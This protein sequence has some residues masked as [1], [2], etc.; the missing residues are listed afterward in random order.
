MGCGVDPE[1]SL[2]GQAGCLYVDVGVEGYLSVETYYFR[3]K[4]GQR[5]SVNPVSQCL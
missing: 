4:S 2:E 3:F 1:S 5:N